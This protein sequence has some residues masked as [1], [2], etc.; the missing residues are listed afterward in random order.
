MSEQVAHLH[1]VEH[2]RLVGCQ[3]DRLPGDIAVGG[4]SH[5][6]LLVGEEHIY[7]HTDMEELLRV[8]VVHQLDAEELAGVAHVFASLRGQHGRH[9]TD[10]DGHVLCP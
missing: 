5:H 4:G 2:L 3:H 1:G 10:A 7:M 6:H 9:R 8:G